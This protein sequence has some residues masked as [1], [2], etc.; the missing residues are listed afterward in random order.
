MTLGRY[1]RREGLLDLRTAEVVV[2]EPAMMVSKLTGASYHKGSKCPRFLRFMQD[3][4]GGDAEMIAYVRRVFG[5]ILTGNVN[6]EKLFFLYGLGANGKT[7]LANVLSFLM[8][9]Y[10]A[11]VLSDILRKQKGNAAQVERA[12]VSLVGARLALMNETR[13]GETW[14]EQKTKELTSNETLSGRRLYQENFNFIPTHKIMVRGNH[15]PMIHDDSEGTWRRL[16]LWA[17]THHVEEKDQ[18]KDIDK[19]LIREEGDAIFTWAVEGCLEYG[20]LGLAPPDK[21]LAEVAQ[22]REENDILGHFFAE[23]V[24]QDRNARA[25][26]AEVYERYKA[27]SDNGRFHTITKMAFARQVRERGFT[28]VKSGAWFYKGLQLIDHG[29]TEQDVWG[30]L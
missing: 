21:V 7:V 6:E 5:Y 19:I 26:V 11:I 23:E 24:T 1:S 18:V 30:G 3:T 29:R 9:E 4:F 10:V 27:W 8:G 28:K 15:K 12:T 13:Q 2:A 16:H 14:D 20:R 22:F 17:F 25:P